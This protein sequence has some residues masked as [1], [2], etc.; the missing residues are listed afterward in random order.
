MSVAMWIATGIHETVWSIV[1][2]IQYLFMVATSDRHLWANRFILQ[3][4]HSGEYDPQ[5]AEADFDT[6]RQGR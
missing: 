1:D 3:L 2:Y 5:I 6:S 4:G